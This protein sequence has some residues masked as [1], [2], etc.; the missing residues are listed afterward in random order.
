M[1]KNFPI[2]IPMDDT[3]AVYFAL[4]WKSYEALSYHMKS[5][6]TDLKRNQGV[7]ISEKTVNNK[8]V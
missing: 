6:N 7:K 2:K 8:Y 1:V 3:N 4:N 5:N